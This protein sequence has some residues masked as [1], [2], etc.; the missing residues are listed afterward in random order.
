MLKYF[1]IIAIRQKYQDDLNVILGQFLKS[2]EKAFSRTSLI[3]L[4]QRGQFIRKY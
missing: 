1:E 2:L 3:T 4:E